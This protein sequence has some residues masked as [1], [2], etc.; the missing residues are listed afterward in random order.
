MKKSHSYAD[1]IV[2]KE[3]VKKFDCLFDVQWRCFDKFQGDTSDFKQIRA[4][5]DCPRER[6]IPDIE[7]DAY[8]YAKVGRRIML[9]SVD[10]KT[11]ERLL[12][13]EK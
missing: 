13:R 4:T 10:K 8:C 1:P 11:T 12:S 5:C 9:E 3:K 2:W 6:E 7:W